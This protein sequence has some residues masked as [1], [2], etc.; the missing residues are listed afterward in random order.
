MKTKNIYRQGDVLIIRVNSIPS[1]AKPAKRDQG[2]IILAY[3]EVTGHSH[4]IEDIHVK[5]FLSGDLLYLDLEKKAKVWHEDH[6]PKDKNL[7]MELPSG[8]YRVINQM[9][10]RRKE[11]VRNTD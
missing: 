2:R 9:E 4:A 1:D 11:L 3:G 5:A 10:F 6:N 7:P 8:K